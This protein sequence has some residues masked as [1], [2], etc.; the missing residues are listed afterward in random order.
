[1]KSIYLRCIMGHLARALA[2]T[3]VYYMQPTKDSL[4]QHDCLA[5]VSQAMAYSLTR[6]YL[7]RHDVYST[8]LDVKSLSVAT[9]LLITEARVQAETFES[10]VA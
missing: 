6:A 10:Q 9:Q 1:M 3:C 5:Q 2:Q 7:Q 8:P 4:R